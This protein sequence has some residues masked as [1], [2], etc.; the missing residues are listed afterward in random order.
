M[1]ILLVVMMIAPG[2]PAIQVQIGM[3]NGPGI[4]DQTG[5][6]IITLLAAESPEVWAGYQ[7]VEQVAA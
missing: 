5:R 7:C 4:C 6:A 1:N 2:E 3:M